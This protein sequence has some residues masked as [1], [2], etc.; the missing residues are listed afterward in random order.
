MT[1][2]LSELGLA[3]CLPGGGGQGLWGELDSSVWG[4][5]NEPY[6]VE[7]GTW[8]VLRSWRRLWERSLFE[9]GPADICCGRPKEKEEEKKVVGWM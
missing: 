6:E 4:F 2:S 9:G 8:C 1:S 3:V 7:L 5:E